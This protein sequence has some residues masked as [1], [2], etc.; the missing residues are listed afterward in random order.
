MTE[1][2]PKNEQTG[3]KHAVRLSKILTEIIWL[4]MLPLFFV[5]TILA[6]FQIREIHEDQLDKASLLAKNVVLYTDNAIN[7]RIKGLG[8]LAA[9]PFMD[10][11]SKWDLFIRRLRVFIKVSGLTWSSRMGLNS[12]SFY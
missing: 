3:T 2:P 7:S 4:C 5:A 6:I 10:D 12:R 9:S 11:L 1:F 8:M